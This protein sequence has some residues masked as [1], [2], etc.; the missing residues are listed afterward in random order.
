[1]R[2]EC[3]IDAMGLEMHW[4]VPWEV[5]STLYVIT[6]HVALHTGQMYIKHFHSFSFSSSEK[7]LTK[8]DR[9]VSVKYCELNS[10]NA[11][12][13]TDYNLHTNSRLEIVFISVTNQLLKL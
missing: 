4:T 5:W 8:M 2:W 9:F 1:M 11:L 12:Q 6:V 7:S 13:F 3:L 10:W